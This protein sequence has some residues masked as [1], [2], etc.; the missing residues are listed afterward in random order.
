MLVHFNENWQLEYES[1]QSPKKLSTSDDSQILNKKTKQK[2]CQM[3][4]QPFSQVFL[5]S[6]QYT[7]QAKWKTCHWTLK[8]IQPTTNAPQI[9]TDFTPE[10]LL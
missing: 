5:G 2:N 6:N 3:S 7:Y 10:Y 8:G 1:F 4:L 9:S